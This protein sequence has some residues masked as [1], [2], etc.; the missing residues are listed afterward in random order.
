[1]L[2]TAA[3]PRLLALKAVSRT[4]VVVDPYLSRRLR[5]HQ[6]EGVA[7]LWEAVSGLRGDPAGGGALLCDEMGLGKTLQLLTLIWTL[8]R[9]SPAGGPACRRAV[10]VCPASLVD[11]WGAEVGKWLGS[12]RLGCTL[13]RGG[14]EAAKQAATEWA[15]PSQTARPMLITSYETLRLIAAQVGQAKP[16]ILVCD[17]AHRLKTESS[18]TL[19][20]LRSLGAARRV[21]LSGTPVQNNLSELYHL[22]SFAAPSLLGEASSFRRIFEAPIAA[23]LERG[24]SR[25][26]KRLGEERNAQL[27]RLVAGVMLRRD[28]S[29]NQAYLPPRQ[30]FVVF[31]R[32]TPLQ[33][34]LYTAFL[35]QPQ[36]RSVAMGGG[37][38]SLPP[39]AAIILLRRLCNSPDAFFASADAAA[40]EGA[41]AAAALQS[42]DSQ[43]VV[44]QLEGL[45]A[46]FAGGQSS[47]KLAVL[48]SMLTS[49]PADER[50][51]VVAGWTQT[52]DL[53]ANLCSQLQVQTAR[54]DGSTPPDARVALVRRFNA[55]GAGRVFLLSTQAG[56]VGLNL[57]GAS[58][59][60]LFDTSWNP[61]HDLQA[62]GRIWVR[63]RCAC[64]SG[65]IM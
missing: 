57:V 35:K 3:D 4:A 58:R 27:M 54:L 7:F 64:A 51:V 49:L 63:E 60:V 8:L 31:V 11:N 25:E 65:P 59:L 40:E 20:A 53:V 6:R 10:V 18:K 26:A 1:V 15:N 44:A 48:A 62:M 55:G 50:C 37:T 12:E 46:G 56:G 14:G 2:C 22:V 61:A 24:A 9:Q 45:R 33:D 41:E 29:V 38:G 42:N 13:I 47:A 39:L 21:L 28:A 34:A 5:P 23:G 17:E 52:L 36:M 30:D 32:P 16:G 19:E 43:R